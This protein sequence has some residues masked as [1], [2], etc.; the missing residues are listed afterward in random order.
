VRVAPSP[1][2]TFKT[3]LS[4]VSALELIGTTRWQGFNLTALYELNI[5]AFDTD[6]L[7]FFYGLGAHVG[8]WGDGNDGPPWLDDDDDDNGAIFGLDGILGL[9]FTF[10]EIPF[11]IGIDWKP[12]LN[13]L[14]NA[15]FWVDE[16][17]LSVRFV[18][19]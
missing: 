14:P 7:N 13:L 18:I 1:G 12:A 17:G 3:F 8:F 19:N 15:D 6:N 5:N 9:E 4:E 11:N 10:N 2:I 16:V